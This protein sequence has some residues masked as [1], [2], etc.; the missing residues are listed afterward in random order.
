MSFPSS[1]LMHHL[2]RTASKGAASS[3]RFSTLNA[4]VFSSLRHCITDSSHSNGPLHLQG[5]SSNHAGVGPGTSA[6]VARRFAQSYPVF[7]LARNPA[8]YESLVQ[9]INEKGGWAKGI[10]TDVSD[11]TSVKNA[12][13]EIREERGKE[14]PRPRR[15]Y[16]MWAGNSSGSLSSSCRQRNSR[17]GGRLKGKSQFLSSLFALALEVM[18]RLQNQGTDIW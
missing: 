8:N 2:P 6:A 10:S 15:E 5:T 14:A 7:L 11:A 13:E 1:S 18:K 17:W 4:P 3:P 9:E 16:S 12:F